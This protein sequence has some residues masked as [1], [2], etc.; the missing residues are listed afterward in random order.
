ML[1]F[2][3]LCLIEF[4]RIEPLQPATMPQLQWT[5][6]NLTIKLHLKR[7][8]AMVSLSININVGGI[9]GLITSK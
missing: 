1:L 7:N 3:E 9:V 6:Y 5:L 2:F 8:N 4:S